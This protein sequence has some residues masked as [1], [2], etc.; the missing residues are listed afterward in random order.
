S[1][2]HVGRFV[3]AATV[4]WQPAVDRAL[5]VKLNVVGEDF[6]MHF[7]KVIIPVVAWMFLVLAF[8][9]AGL[10]QAVFG[11][12]TGTVTAPT[13]AAVPNAKIAITDLD[14]GIIYTTTTTSVG[15]FT[16]THLLAGHY[17]V[18]VK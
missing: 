1:T 9:P 7:P 12:I 6:I 10:G 14:R 15:N 18:K 17:R 16:Q 3:A 13:G 8:S 11:N 4:P 2:S 5:Q